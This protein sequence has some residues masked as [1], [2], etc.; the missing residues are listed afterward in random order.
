[1][2]A[3]GH[4]PSG[5]YRG[6]KSDA[7]DGG[8]RMPFILR[9]PGVVKPGTTCDELIC[10][11]DLMAT[12]AEIVGTELP[13]N[14][15]EDSFSILPLLKGIK[16]PVRD[17]VVSH[18]INGKFAIRDGCWKL[19]LCPGSGGW[20]QSDEAAFN[21]GLPMVQLYDMTTDPGEKHNLHA[22]H[23]DKVRALLEKL[24]KLVA[25]GRSTPGAKQSNDAPVDI[26][27]LET[28]PGSDLEFLD[29]Y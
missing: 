9:W 3:Q 4:F 21:D 20:T 25:D 18:S 10:L 2:E 14:A 7:W 15:G 16:Q 13:A 22:T 6:Y 24:K 27:K 12:C 29:D 17:H 23:P 19:V 11:S 8:H 5:P 1:M 26:W 28:I